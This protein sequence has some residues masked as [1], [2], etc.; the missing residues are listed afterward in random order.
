[1]TLRKAFPK[2]ALLVVSQQV[3]TDTTGKQ[4]IQTQRWQI[5]YEPYASRF[6]TFH[7][8]EKLLYSAHV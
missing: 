2:A 4:I 7:L 6:N 8:A 5:G 3:M 1:M